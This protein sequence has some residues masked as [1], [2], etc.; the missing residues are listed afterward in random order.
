M[1][2]LGIE[3]VFVEPAAADSPAAAYLA[4][5]DAAT[6]Y[7][8][9]LHDAASKRQIGSASAMVTRVRGT[10]PGVSFGS[11]VNSLR[12]LPLEW[13]C[14]FEGSH[15]VSGAEV[16][17]NDLLGEGRTDGFLLLRFA[18]GTRD[19]PLHIHPSSDRFIFAI[20]GRGFFHISADPLA[21]IDPTR[22]HHMPVRDRDALMFAQG[23]VHT[24]STA[25]HELLLLSYHRPF[26][27]LDDPDQYS[28][29]DPPVTPHQF[30]PGYASKISFDAA[31]TIVSEGKQVAGLDR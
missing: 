17:G 26:I 1:L 9:R 10:G 18:P 6:F 13:I 11:L 3:P 27:G 23:A 30:L 25:E 4:L 15:N 28:V 5:A 14:P 8:G 16:R 22:V 29:S 21:A 12:S 31:W 19:L 24:F 20:G 7:L 2:A